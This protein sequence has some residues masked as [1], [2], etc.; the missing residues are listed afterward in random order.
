[1]SPENQTDSV[2]TPLNSEATYTNDKVDVFPVKP[3]KSNI[4]QV[5][6]KCA[7]AGEVCKIA[8]HTKMDYTRKQWKAVTRVLDRFFA[9]VFFIVNIVAIV[10]LFPRAD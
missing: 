9:S 7:D 6:L 8:D 4:T 2:Q 3:S 1:M 5:H 10:L